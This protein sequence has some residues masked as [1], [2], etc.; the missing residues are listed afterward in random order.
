MIAFAAMLLMA[1]AAAALVATGMP[2]APRAYLRFACA[3]LAAL[4]AAAAWDG[5]LAVSMALVACATAPAMLAMAARPVAPVLVM[6]VVAG[7]GLAAALT[8]LAVLALAPLLF[9]ALALI[10][11]RS[12]SPKMW[13]AS[14]ALAAG[15][16]WFAFGDLPALMAFLSAAVLGIALALR[17]SGRRAGRADGG[18]AHKRSVSSRAHATPA[19]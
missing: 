1:A 2:A 6:G 15:A 8:G 9:S 10:A 17:E 16:V 7:L 3:L 5:A 4:A 12:A 19:R 11:A 14:L 13:A 18:F